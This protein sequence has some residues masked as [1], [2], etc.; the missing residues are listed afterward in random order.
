MTPPNLQGL[1]V[2]HPTQSQNQYL[3]DSQDLLTLPHY[4]ELSAQLD[5]WTN[6]AFESDEPLVRRDDMKKD[7]SGGES[8]SPPMDDMERDEEEAAGP[9]RAE[10]HDNV[11]MGNPINDSNS[12]TAKQ[13]N[14]QQQQQQQQLDISAL[15]AGFGVD[16]FAV[17]TLYQQPPPSAAP[18]LAQILALYPSHATGY[19]HPPVQSPAA[20]AAPA[21]VQPAA[22]RARTRKSSVS[23]NAE[24]DASSPNTITFPS[25]PDTAGQSALSPAEDKRRRNTAASARFRLKKK[26]REAALEKKAKEL[27]VKVTELERECE[28]LR[29]ENGWLKGLVVGVTGVGATQPGPSPGLGSKRQREDD[30]K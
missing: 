25:G 21:Q 12:S 10:N 26:E 30:S 5:L 9:A 16:P 13:Q 22:K 3:S 23:T 6:L 2:V 17:P 4:P 27:E 20:A 7:T 1:N 19:P 28:G 14:Q 11:V 24:D 18:S 8:S 15:L 29:R